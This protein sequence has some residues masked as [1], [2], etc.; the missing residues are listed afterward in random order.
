MHVVSFC[1]IMEL[2][3]N[4]WICLVSLKELPKVNRCHLCS[5]IYMVNVTRD[6]LNNLRLNW[7]GVLAGVTAEYLS[8]YSKCLEAGKG[9]Y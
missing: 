6:R 1:S 4:F 5:K 9:S 2:T 8:Y 3:Y 7:L